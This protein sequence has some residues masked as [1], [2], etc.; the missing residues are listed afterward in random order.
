MLKKQASEGDLCGAVLIK[1][2]ED[3][4]RDANQHKNQG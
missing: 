4:Q 1:K 3:L 2:I